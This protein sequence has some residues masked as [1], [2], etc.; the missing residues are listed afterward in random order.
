MIVTTS[1]NNMWGT[2]TW[3]GDIDGKA[4]LITA[5]RIGAALW[6]FESVKGGWFKSNKNYWDLKKRYPNKEEAYKDLNISV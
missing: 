2:V 3:S 6:V 4:A 1:S 5:S